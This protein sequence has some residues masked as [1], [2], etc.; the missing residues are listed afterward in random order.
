L[1]QSN[2][3]R[4]AINAT[5]TYDQTSGAPIRF[6]DLDIR[7][8]AASEGEIVSSGFDAELNSAL[9]RHDVDTGP[10]PMIKDRDGKPSPYFFLT[11][12]GRRRAMSIKKSASR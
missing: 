3:S 10:H 1:A 6:Y 5:E 2:K 8:R 11:A 9:C 7:E 12:K 4:P